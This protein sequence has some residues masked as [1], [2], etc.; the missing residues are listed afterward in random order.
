FV[1]RAQRRGRRRDEGSVRA[2]LEAEE[3][4]GGRLDDHAAARKEPLSLALAQSDPQDQ[5]VLHR[6]RARKTSDEEAHPRDLPQRRGI[7]RARVRRG[8]RRALLLSRIGVRANARASRA[9]RGMPSQSTLDDS[10]KSEQAIALASAHDSFPLASLGL[11]V[12]TP[13]T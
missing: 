11:L 10:G 6:A 3:S 9:A 8:S 5:G 12:R 7:G 1:L 4:F 2:Q 13:S